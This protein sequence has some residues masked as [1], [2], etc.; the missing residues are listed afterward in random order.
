MDALVDAQ[1]SRDPTGTSGLRARFRA[2][3][4]LQLRQL[5]AQMRTA[6]IDRDVLGLKP[7]GVMAYHEPAVRLHAFHAWLES[8]AGYF[9]DHPWPARFIDQAWK[10]GRQVALSE[11]GKN[12]LLPN[13]STSVHLAQLA[14]QELI[15]IAAATV[16]TVSRDAA[17]IIA[18]KVKPAKAW[19]LLSRTFDK[20]AVNRLMAMCN[21]LIVAAHN[22]AKIETY[23]AA[24]FSRVGIVPETVA[25]PR[26]MRDASVEEIIAE[27]LE[28]AGALEEPEF[29]E[30]LVGVLTAGDKY[31][32]ELCEDIADDSPF[33]LDEALALL[34]VHPNCRCAV[35]P[36][37]GKTQDA[38]EEQKHPRG[39]H[40]RWV[41][42]FI[43]PNISNLTFAQASAGLDTRRQRELT[44][45]SAQ[46]NSALN[47]QAREQRAIGAWSDG[48]E[49]SLISTMPSA[50]PEVAR[51]A[52]AMKGYLADQKAVLLFT[53]STVGTEVMASFNAQGS[54]ENIHD[55]LL[56][57]GIAFHTLEPHVTG[58]AT[59]HVYANDAPVIH[60]VLETAKDYG[61]QVKLIRGR[62]EFLGAETQ[63]S[64]REQRD[65]ARQAYQRV[66]EQ[67][68]AARP[69]RHIGDT[70]DRIRDHWLP[71]LIQARDSGRVGPRPNLYFADIGW[72]Q[73]A[74]EA[75]L[76]A[77]R[78]KAEQHAEAGQTV[79]RVINAV[80][81]AAEKIRLARA[82]LARSVRTD[83]PVEQGGHKTAD[84]KW[85][86]TRQELHSPILEKILT[87]EKVKAATP[88][89]G[90]RPVVHL[91]GGS[92]GS[93]KS[94]YTGPN[95]T[96]KTDNAIYINSDDVK[97]M[98]PEYRGWNAA[99]VHEESSHIAKTAETVARDHKLN[100]II[101]GTM[102]NLAALQKR[103]TQYKAAGYRVEGHFMQVAHETSAKRA[104]QRFVRGSEGRQ[105][106][107]FVAPEM[108]MA[109]AA[110]QNFETVR[111][112]MDAWELY[113]NEGDRPR[114][115]SRS[116]VHDEAPYREEE[117]PRDPKGQW[118][119][120]GVVAS[121]RI[122]AKRVKAEG[123]AR[124]DVAA[125]K[126]DP[127]FYQ[128]TVELFHDQ[129]GYPNFRKEDLKGKTLD[130][131]V[132]FI[133][134]QMKSNLKF[135]YE[136]ASADVK[137]HGMVWYD[138]AHELCE[139]DAHQ[140]GLPV[141]AAAG[142]M[143]ALS[144]QK[145][146]DQNIYLAHRVIE[147]TQTQREHVWDE[148]MDAVA[149]QIWK[150]KD[151][152]LVEAIKGKS[153]GELT[154]FAEKA[155]WVRTFDEAHSTRSY[156]E[157]AL[158]GKLGEVV[159]TAKGEPAKAA[160]SS[161]EIISNSIECAESNGDLKKISEALG[162]R[163]KVRSFYNNI[164][165]PRASTE[166][167][168]VDTH[169]VGAALL[170]SPSGAETPVM[171][172]LHLT[173]PSNAKPPG[174]KASGKSAKLGLSGNYAIYADAY[175]EAAHELGIVPQQ[176][177]AIAWQAKRDL[178]AKIDKADVEAIW[179]DY[180]E[181]KHS[182]AETQ[183]KVWD[184]GL[185]PA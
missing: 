165:A 129:H 49:N 82:L 172:A 130:Q 177:Q 142:V 84:G 19:Q 175:R 125:L 90:E 67:S 109:H 89:S 100:L 4:K 39:E 110:T 45:A 145:D 102:G 40:G 96:V 22:Q 80:P 63:G 123:Y 116:Q 107:R 126:S 171:H 43:S 56:K 69:N 65:A 74:R 105:L 57:A 55:K 120:K 161:I 93:G 138:A 88:K 53:A 134:D 41:Q 36:W 156:R 1:R 121:R 23:R 42:G 122:T 158:G 75:A 79:A 185:S 119:E 117:H 132:S 140:Y 32:C 62:G 164:V 168:T 46:I 103:V 13:N 170:R 127:I 167:V 9:L 5:R 181:G 128:K 61:S 73:E 50:D 166:D 147:I 35:Y 60:A 28:E 52:A 44:L 139:K 94:W 159:T 169:A 180:N 24:G 48:A 146:W 20:V 157:F 18:R 115:V 108:L 133:T 72:T 38:Y 178:F 151:R 184:L 15:G 148:K 118:T 141:E 86:P 64:D 152:E 98:L 99:L 179:R 6:V 51:A 68:A 173:P 12:E 150:P 114:L 8:M 37:T 26:R 7:D 183:Q 14:K 154:A 17:S 33:T 85:T 3:A 155:A 136:H 112:D 144:P 153:Y 25:P 182:L 76:A 29:E 101:D 54:L 143:A 31:V 83:A 97:A 163:H 21:V 95:G 174:W 11:V 106:G 47:L 135:L 10:S 34:P 77:R 30:P 131:Q 92:G 70:W 59:V 58:G 27:A 66:I 71:R 149:K 176:L 91:L 160:W 104:L 137:S 2:A 16:Q 124:P 111:N 162:E 78:A 87:P 81:G 113:E